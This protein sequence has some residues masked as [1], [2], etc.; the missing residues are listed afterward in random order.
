MAGEAAAARAGLAPIDALE[1]AWGRHDWDAMRGYFTP[2]AVVDDHRT[3]GM[4]RLDPDRWIESWRVGGDLAPDVRAE[5]LRILAWNR[6]GRVSVIRVFGTTR[7]GGP[8]ESLFSLV[9]VAEGDRVR[10]YEFFNV[11][12]TDEAVARFEELCSRLA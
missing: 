11:G 10:N 8:F 2:D 7:D 4:G 1:R 12:D 3:L 6:H 5:T 9:G